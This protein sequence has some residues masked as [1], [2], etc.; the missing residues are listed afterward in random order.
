[1]YKKPYRIQSLLELSRLDTGLPV[2]IWIDSY[3]DLRNYVRHKKIGLLSFQTNY[4]SYQQRQSSG[5]ISLDTGKVVNLDWLK[6]QPCYRLNDKDL[7]HLEIFVQN[8]AFA[9]SFIEIQAISDLDFLLD[10][11]IDSKVKVAEELK[12]NQFKKTVQLITDRLKS[13]YYDEPNFFLA[14]KKSLLSRVSEKMLLEKF[15]FK[16]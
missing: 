3:C 6:V 9:L 5:K 4:S 13:N 15:D 10:L 14:V 12:T 11:M 7:E 8:N 1:M 16:F 2:N